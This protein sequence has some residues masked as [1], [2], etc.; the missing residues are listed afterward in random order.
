MYYDEGM[1]G[2]HWGS[3]ASGLLLT[4]GDRILL[5]L[6]SE[7]VQDPGFW[8]IPG[9]AI[10]VDQRGDRKDALQSAVDETREETGLQLPPGSEVVG[11][12]IFRDGSFS[13]T[14]YLVRVPASLSRARV[15]LNWE[16]DD[17]GW[18]TQGEVEELIAA[19]DLH[20][21]VVY[22]LRQMLPFLAGS[23]AR[24]A[25]RRSVARPARPRAG[26]ARKRGPAAYN[27]LWTSLQD[28]LGEISIRTGQKHFRVIDH[29]A[30]VGRWARKNGL[31][32]LGMG[33]FRVVLGLPEGALKLD[34]ATQDVP[35]SKEYI[36]IAR[37]KQ[38]PTKM[39]NFEA[40]AWR[41]APRAAKAHLVPVLASDPQG[42]WL[43]SEVTQPSTREPT[44]DD[45]RR[46]SPVAVS[47]GMP[48]KQ[49]K[50][51]NLDVKGRLLDYGWNPGFSTSYRESAIRRGLR[52]LFKG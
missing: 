19:G 46:L 1:V 5:L 45:L 36:W 29:A 14:T 21:G 34:L 48:E 44:R 23:P 50:R 26:V 25:V 9:G 17:F 15:R 22:T 18:F 30:D 16:N 43:L 8:G 38:V 20:H 51:G 3:A 49:I 12:T 37:R 33:A 39:N 35:W 41:L 42:R 10:P 7:D 32:L 28:A 47:I 31:K 24:A 52:R 40:R 4:T 6:R 11:E 27:R 2:N 13:F